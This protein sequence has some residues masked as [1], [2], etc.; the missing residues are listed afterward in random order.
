MYLE[1][2]I[3]GIVGK[4][5]PTDK[6]TS[7]HVTDTASQKYENYLREYTLHRNKC[8]AIIRTA[9]KD[10]RDMLNE[11]DSQRQNNITFHISQ[12]NVNT[13]I[14]QMSDMAH[15][16]TNKIYLHHKLHTPDTNPD[17]SHTINTRR[18]TVKVTIGP[19]RQTT[20]GMLKH[21]HITH[22]HTHKNRTED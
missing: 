7:H 9:F 17:G 20:L 18:G 10:I 21:N 6:Y 4:I 11:R 16:G 3:R 22:T 5:G 13:E 1:S 14:G 19:D 12:H 2:E 15:Q 8:I